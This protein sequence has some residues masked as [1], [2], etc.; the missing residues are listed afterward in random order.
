MIKSRQK[1][2]SNWGPRWSEGRDLIATAQTM[3]AKREGKKKLGGGVRGRYFS[4]FQVFYYT[5]KLK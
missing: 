4:S 5:H 1:R 3:P 2:E